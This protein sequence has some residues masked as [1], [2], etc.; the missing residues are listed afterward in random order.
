MRTALR[1]FLPFV[2]A[3][4][5][6][7]AVAVAP[8]AVAEPQCLNAPPNLL[9]QDLQTCPSWDT[10]YA[11]QPS[12]IHNQSTYIYPWHDPFYGSASVIDWP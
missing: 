11:T 6:A 9:G 8:A 2:A 12:Q 10:Q 1:L 5:A 7:A 4:G 3:A